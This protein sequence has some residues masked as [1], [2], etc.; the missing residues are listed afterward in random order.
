MFITNHIQ[1]HWCEGLCTINRKCCVKREVMQLLQQLQNITL[2]YEKQYFAIFATVFR[3]TIWASIPK[4][5]IRTHA[6]EIKRKKTLRNERVP[7][8]G[9]RCRLTNLSFLFNLLCF[10]EYI[11]LKSVLSTWSKCRKFLISH[12]PQIRKNLETLYPYLSNSNMTN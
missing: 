9:S 8:F 12:Q 10:A 1:S 6:F 7:D 4:R 11:N 3:Y 5:E 2:R